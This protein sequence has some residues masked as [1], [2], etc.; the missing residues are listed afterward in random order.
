MANTNTS[1]VY[2]AEPG[3]AFP[4]DA[5]ELAWAQAHGYVK[6]DGYTGPGVSNTGA[7]DVAPAQDQTL[8]SNRE[9]APAYEDF[10]PLDPAMVFDDEA[11]S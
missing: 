2:G 4:G 6:S 8:A 5:D 11:E 9:A 3:E 7:A 1:E 10:G